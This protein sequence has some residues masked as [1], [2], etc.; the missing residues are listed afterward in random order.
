M[1]TK[2]YQYPDQY[3]SYGNYSIDDKTEKLGADEAIEKINNIM[4]TSRMFNNL[5]NKEVIEEII[6][7]LDNYYEDR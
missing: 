5:D 4:W 2:K 3:D 6:K 1:I 7:I